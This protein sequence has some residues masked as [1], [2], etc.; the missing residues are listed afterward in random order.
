MNFHLSSRIASRIELCDRR[1]SVFLLLQSKKDAK[2]SHGSALLCVLSV[3]ILQVYVTALIYRRKL[4]LSHLHFARCDLPYYR[5]SFLCI[6]LEPMEA[7]NLVC[8]KCRLCMCMIMQPVLLCRSSP[9]LPILRR[10][11]CVWLCVPT[12]FLIGSPWCHRQPKLIHL[13]NEKFDF[14]L[15]CFWWVCRYESVGSCSSTSS[16]TTS[17]RVRLRY[18]H[19]TILF[20]LF[21][22]LVSHRRE[23]R[24]EVC[25]L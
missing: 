7:S 11:Q 25:C 17:E 10:G 6:I 12:E 19:L 20:L 3:W 1:F 4:I 21:P 8:F 13:Q 22:P 2:A 18:S 16:T 9:R 15:R 5:M 14:V 24:R 23:F